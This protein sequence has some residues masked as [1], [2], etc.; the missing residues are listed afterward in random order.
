[1]DFAYRVV[2]LREAVLSR[3][4]VDPE[5]GLRDDLAVVA[6][7]ADARAGSR[8]GAAAARAGVDLNARKA[9]G[10][11][12]E[13]ISRFTNGALREV[14][15]GGHVVRVAS[16]DLVPGDIVINLRAR[17]D[18]RA[19][20]RDYEWFQCSD[21]CDDAVLGNEDAVFAA[22]EQLSYE[23]RAHYGELAVEDLL[24]AQR[25]HAS[26]GNYIPADMLI[27][28][29]EDGGDGK[30]G[31]CTVD[32]SALTGSS[33]SSL[34]TAARGTLR[35]APSDPLQSPQFLWHK[36]QLLTGTVAKA[37]VVATHEKTLSFVRSLAMA[38]GAHVEILVEG[39]DEEEDIDGEEKR[40]SLGDQ[41]AKEDNP[42]GSTTPEQAA[43][44]TAV[45]R[46]HAAA[47]LSRVD[48][49]RRFWDA[50]VLVFSQCAGLAGAADAACD[51]RD[52]LQLRGFE[53][54]PQ[55]SDDLGGLSGY[56]PAS[57]RTSDMQGGALRALN[58]SRAPVDFEDAM[59][60]LRLSHRFLAECL[61][62][63]RASLFMAR[64]SCRGGGEADDADGDG[65]VTAAEFLF[66]DEEEDCGVV[67]AGASSKKPGQP[68]L[69]AVLGLTMR[70][71]SSMEENFEVADT[72]LRSCIGTP[73]VTVGA[74]E[75]TRYTLLLARGRAV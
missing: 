51:E 30:E 40:G 20:R 65:G 8:A 70:K 56:D 16:Q 69:C 2:H 49:W 11:L 75:W 61:E 24:R 21:E 46:D 34:R 31:C 6:A 26:A 35:N 52:R 3:F 41:D 53:G 73:G 12:S 23:R 38:S 13:E 9:F 5:V 47:F 36:T 54:K 15:R 64:E 72:L 33:T 62:K 29:I 68:S 17:G 1:M 55:R 28:E 63:A 4:A 42:R 25:Q 45:A 14:L 7:R 67:R 57:V 22:F 37:V 44:A 60:R 27:L 71:L 19:P 58:V 39:R 59:R 43:A 10:F 50:F 32:M 18:I 48:D 66:E 74:A